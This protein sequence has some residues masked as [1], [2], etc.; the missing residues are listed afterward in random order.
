[1]SSNRSKTGVVRQQD[2]SLTSVALIMSLF[3]TSSSIFSTTC[4]STTSHLV[5]LAKARQFSTDPASSSAYSNSNKL[6]FNMPNAMQNLLKELVVTS[7]T[8]NLRKRYSSPS[9]P[10][11]SSSLNHLKTKQNRKDSRIYYISMPPMP[12]RFIPGIGYDY[13]PVK[14]RPLMAVTAQQQPQ[15]QSNLIPTLAHQQKVPSP[16]LHSGNVL[17]SLSTDKNKKSENETKITANKLTGT[18][19]QPSISL[20]PATKKDSKIYHLSPNG[21][22]GYFFNGRPTRLQVFHGTKDVAKGTSSDKL[23]S[24]FKVMPSLYFNKNIIF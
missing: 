14:I 18:N 13:Q 22:G 6:I 19:T 16:N 5:N 12:Y 20:T 15:P 3:W 23:K 21:S 4:T 7:R 9:L 24:P 1:M 8:L 17:D 2:F 11:S 10:Y